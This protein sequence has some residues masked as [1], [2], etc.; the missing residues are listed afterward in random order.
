MLKK[1]SF[2]IVLFFL[3]ILLGCV[4]T[5]YVL[6]NETPPILDGF[7]GFRWTTPISV[8]DSEFPKRTGVTSM[9]SLNHYNTS[10]FSDAYFLGEIASLCW[11]GF[12]QT[13][14]TSVKILFNTNY[15]NCED[16]LYLLKDSLSEI[17]GEPREIPG[18]IEPNTPP[19]Y[20][21][22]Y[23]WYEKRLNISLNIDFTIE[24]NAYSFSLLNRPIF[25]K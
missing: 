25:N 5:N 22:S 9:D 4:E 6:Q 3:F 23:F 14:L 17:Y 19:T 11:F 21:I 24:I 18:I 20:S 12:G 10:N 8:V 7:F 15:L 2:W 16:K 1:I 13:G